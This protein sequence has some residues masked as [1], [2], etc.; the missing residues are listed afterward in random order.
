MMPPALVAAIFSIASC[1]DRP[2]QYATN[3]IVQRY[4]EPFQ[5]FEEALDLI[6]QGKESEKPQLLNA[7]APSITNCQVLTILSLQQHGV[8]EYSRA[9]ILC[10][11][12]SAMAIE[13]RLHRPYESNDPI[14]SEVHSRL[15]W[16]LYILE[17]MSSTEMGRPVMLRYEETDCPYPSV[18]EADEFELMSTQAGNQGLSG[19][20]R[21]TAIKLRTLSGLHSTIRLSIILEKISREIYGLSSR[22]VIRDNQA[23]G[24]A[25]RMD[26]WYALK[27]W[28]REME[29]SPLRLDL[30]KDLTSVPA[31]IT[32][33]V[34]SSLNITTHPSSN[35]SDYV[36]RY[37]SPPSTIHCSLAIKSWS[38]T[39]YRQPAQCLSRRGQKYLPR[40]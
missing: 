19:Q 36:P 27:E 22:K 13:M 11:L 17:K 39:S 24:E 8:A 28:E 23:S 16:N 21:N 18:S 10:G 30:S 37:Y 14:Q 26:L 12:A 40:S 9:A 5:F 35:H 33:Y 31:A 15:W 7:L 1:V 4:P 34:V 6:Q 3:T 2:Q 29:E 32:N 20:I 38:F 25:K